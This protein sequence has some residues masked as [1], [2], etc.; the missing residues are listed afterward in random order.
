MIY[1]SNI[2]SKFVWIAIFDQSFY[3]LRRIL[4]FSHVCLIVSVLMGFVFVWS[5]FFE[6]Y[7]GLTKK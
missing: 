3:I 1:H 5:G 7:K 4:H 6:Y 2:I